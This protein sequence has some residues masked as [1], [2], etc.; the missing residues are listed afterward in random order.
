[1]SI[2]A[3][4]SPLAIGTETGGSNV[5]PASVNGLYGLT[6]P[7]H[8]VPTD[9]V[10]KISRTY[11]AIGVMARDPWDVA[12]LADVLLPSNREGGYA[13]G[14]D[15]AWE[16]ISVGIVKNT[17]GVQIIPDGLGE[18]GKW[19]SPDMVGRQPH[20]PC[21]RMSS[22]PLMRSRSRGTTRLRKPSNRKL[23]SLSFPWISKN[24]EFSNMKAK[25]PT[26]FLVSCKQRWQ[27]PDIPGVTSGPYFTAKLPLSIR[28]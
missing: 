20:P 1:M 18:Q 25:L 14:M 7:R 5:L 9:G 21:P 17:W 11:D 28:L 6:L 24:P 12:E 27:C 19:E 16:G 26:R 3:G 8:S 23:E 2:S 13:S 10:F 22:K 15:G 4:F